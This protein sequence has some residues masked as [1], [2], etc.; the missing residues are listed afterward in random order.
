MLKIIYRS[1]QWQSKAKQNKKNSFFWGLFGFF[2]TNLKHNTY[3]FVCI[4]IDRVREVIVYIYIYLP[5]FKYYISYT[6]P[7]HKKNKKNSHLYS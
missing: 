4:A 5:I 7:H 1:E 6:Q 2:F 3:V